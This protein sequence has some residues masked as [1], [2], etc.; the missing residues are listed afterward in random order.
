MLTNPMSTDLAVAAAP[1]HPQLVAVGTADT[2]GVDMNTFLRALFLLDVGVFGALATVDMKLQESVD[3]LVYTDVAGFSITQLLA[4]GG[5]NK[6]A[7]IEVRA[8]QLTKRY[9]RA[10]VTVG[11]ADTLLQVTPLG[12]NTNFGVADDYDNATVV[13]KK[14]VAGPVRSYV[15]NALRVNDL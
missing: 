7:S 6:V 14:T 10:R 11:V 8:E 9:V 15:T 2:G 1:I 3:D 13:Q 5:D 12:G 4:A